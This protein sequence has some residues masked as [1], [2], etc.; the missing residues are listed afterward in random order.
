[1]STISRG[2]FAPTFLSFH[3]PRL[4]PRLMNAIGSTAANTAATA[5]KPSPAA[6]SACQPIASVVTMS[7]FFGSSR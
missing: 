6:P 3:W 7:Q 1:M 5:P 4:T 2:R